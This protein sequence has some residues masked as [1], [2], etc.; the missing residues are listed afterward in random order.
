MRDR[1]RTRGDRTASASP[2]VT[3]EDA[4]GHEYVLLGTRVDPLTMDQAV[5]RVEE[6]LD[7]RSGHHNHLAMNAA[8]L[9]AGA[10]D[11]VL[12]ERFSTASLVT[13]DGQS[14]VWASKFL[15]SPLPERV[16]GIDLMDRL[17]DLSAVKGYRIY[18]LGA[19]D[20]VVRQV[21]W[22]FLARNAEVVGFHD[23][24]WRRAG[25]TDEAMA[26]EIA[27]TRADIV[28]VGVPSPLKEDF[29][30]AQRERTGAGMCVG[31]G[32]SFDIVAGLTSRAPHWMQRAGLEWFWRFAQEPRRM[33]KRYLVGNS[34]FLWLVLRARL[35]RG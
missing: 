13:A 11:P 4:A 21:R 23:G 2:W 28:F 14:L 18:L 7:E 10:R 31:V 27:R 26:E 24:F 9:V 3:G 33:F 19:T 17:V 29:I 6:L 34:I 12:R 35:R 30:F 8:K 32:G 25:I 20:D 15:G 1:T 5:A 16:A 22:R